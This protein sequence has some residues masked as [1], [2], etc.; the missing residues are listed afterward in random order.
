MPAKNLPV[1]DSGNIESY[2]QRIRG[3]SE[4]FFHLN[5]DVFIGEPIEPGEWFGPQ[6][7]VAMEASPTP[8]LADLDPAETALVNAACLSSRWLGGRYRGYRHDPRI[9]AHAP[10]PM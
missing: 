4:R 2:I 6:L 3:L 8:A 9:Y 5:D 10:R 7:T 1:F